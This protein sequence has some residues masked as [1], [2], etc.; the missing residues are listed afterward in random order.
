[1]E[2]ME[3][4]GDICGMVHACIHSGLTSPLARSIISTVQVS[5]LPK[6]EAMSV[7]IDCPEEDEAHESGDD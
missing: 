7:L 1:M 6:L 2:L 4:G 3:H 5:N